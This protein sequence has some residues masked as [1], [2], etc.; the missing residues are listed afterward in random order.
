MQKKI[1][2]PLI[3]IFLG[4][5]I[6]IVIGELLV[7]FK[8]LHPWT[9]EE[10]QIRVEPGG[11]LYGRHGKFG[12]IPIQG[13][14]RIVLYDE[15]QFKVT[16]LETGQRITRPL[17]E[18]KNNDMR[19]EIWI[20]G[21]SYTY[22]WAVNDDENFPWYVQQSLPEFDVRNYGVSGYGDLH[23]LLQFGED[24]SLEQAPAI[25]V[26]AYASFH[27][28]RNTFLRSKRKMV[29]AY[30]KLGP[31]TM[32]YAR[33]VDKGE[34]KILMDS[35]AFW[36]PPLMRQS[37]LV[38]LIERKYNEWEELRNESHAVSEAIVLELA[39]RA[40]HVGTDLIVAGINN[41]PR[42]L[43]MLHFASR[44]GIHSVNISVDLSAGKSGSFQ[45]PEG[46][47]NALAHKH[48]AQ[49]LVEYLK[50]NSLLNSSR[51]SLN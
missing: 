51:R 5:C 19:P 35:V 29:A 44:N 25:A 23:S 33:L 2:F 32:P 15:I 20:F 43:D 28:S 37:A 41:A 22:G 1:I 46:H 8:G 18:Y 34:L 6:A 26:L 21:C 45:T 13:T 4:I 24:A 10:P 49:M 9:P 39:K 27:D 47:P 36:E 11:K 50:E 16:H 38:Y 42:S 3:S 30:N 40:A 31:V 12:Y 14:F 7:R 17:L 48:F